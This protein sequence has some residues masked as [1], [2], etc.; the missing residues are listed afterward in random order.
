MRGTICI[1]KHFF[2][3]GKKTSEG[4]KTES[5]AEERCSAVGGAVWLLWP[6]PT[7]R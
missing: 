6:G 4:E 5:Q 3:E 1:I 2:K 7:A